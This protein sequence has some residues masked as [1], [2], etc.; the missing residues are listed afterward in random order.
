M[1]AGFAVTHQNGKRHAAGRAE[2]EMLDSLGPHAGS[3]ICS[4]NRNVVD[5]ALFQIEKMG[6]A[7]GVRTLSEHGSLLRVDS[8]DERAWRNYCYFTTWTGKGM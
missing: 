5:A 8:N 3:R 2:P 6:A 4:V 1:D 7:D